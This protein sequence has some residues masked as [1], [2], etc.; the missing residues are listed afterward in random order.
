[1][2]PVGAATPTSHSACAT[3]LSSS[4]LS[5][6]LRSSS[7]PVSYSKP[8]SLRPLLSYPLEETP[9]PI[10][11]IMKHLRR[12]LFGFCLGAAGLIRTCFLWINSDY[13]TTLL[14]T[15]PGYHPFP[16]PTLAWSLLDS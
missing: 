3:A 9:T 4:I 1:M 8:L 16:P 13:Y 6:L 11:W 2:P 7:I 12:V 5:L 14:G 15:C 10:F